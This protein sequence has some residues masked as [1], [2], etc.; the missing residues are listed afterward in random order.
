[1]AACVIASDGPYAL[2]HYEGRYVLDVERALDGIRR[3]AA[4][5]LG[6]PLLSD[7]ADAQWLT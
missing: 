3:A 1:M 7:P 5:Q 6:R 4:F 2:A